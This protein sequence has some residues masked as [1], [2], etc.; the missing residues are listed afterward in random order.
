MS[1]NEF[2]SQDEA[3]IYSNVL[4][5]LNCAQINKR[6]VNVSQLF[7]G[8]HFLFRSD[9]METPDTIYSFASQL[10]PREKNP[11]L[12]WGSI[13]NF[14][15]ITLIAIRAISGLLVNLCRSLIF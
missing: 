13:L 10:P 5:L 4:Y 9:I 12:N 14:R 15:K 3:A 11:H 8:T 7:Q 2:Q 1:L 6:Q